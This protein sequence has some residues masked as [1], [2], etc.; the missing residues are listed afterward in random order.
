MMTENV[1]KNIAKLIESSMGLT[2]QPNRFSEYTKQLNSVIKTLGY[3]NLDAFY[4]KISRSNNSLSL[5]EKKII[6]THL[7]VSETYFFRE[8]PA[9]SMFKN[10][11]IPE[12]IRKKNGSL[13]TIWCAGCSSGEEPYT[14]SMILKENFPQ[15]SSENYK[16]IATDI[17]PNV[18][19][20]AKNGI[21]TQWSFREMPDKYLKKYFV[22]EGNN[23]KISDR[24]KNSVIFEFLNL[25]SDPF[26]GESLKDEPIDIIFCRNVLMYLNHEIIKKIAQRFYNILNDSGWF[27]PSQ[28]ELNDEF[29]G[30]FNKIYSED[31]VFY[32]KEKNETT[33]LIFPFSLNKTD[34][35]IVKKTKPIK[36]KKSFESV[37][38]NKEKENTFSNSQLENLFSDGKYKECIEISKE[39]IETG[40]NNVFLLQ[41]IAKCYANTGE[42]E[43]AILLLDQLISKGGSSDDIFYLYGTILIEQNQ[44]EEAK[45]MF[46]KGLYMNSEHLLSHLMLG[47][48][49]RIEGNNRAASIHYRNVYEISLKI[50]D[51][52]LVRV[53]GGLNGERIRELV[54]KYIKH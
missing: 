48:I 34:K 28:V 26:P 47:N 12:I 51:D 17:N 31:A 43:K 2:F 1:A 35:C 50:K 21:Y 7:T 27:I 32:K 20:K 3:D 5:D 53:S 11:I 37:N 24:I 41:T 39:E 29:F 8:A 9:I 44:I 30:H 33:K 54:E 16:I 40:S 10:K 6:A 14:L 38:Y 25:A 18:L 4:A 52:D 36:D 15:L 13:I 19:E 22:K 23:Y 42:Y 45:A 49:L 46:K